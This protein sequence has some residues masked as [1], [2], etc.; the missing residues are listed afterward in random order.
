MKNK[1]F[2][3]SLLAF[4][5]LLGGLVL[6]PVSAQALSMGPNN[7]GTG[8]SV[9]GIGTI[10]WSNTG[11][12]T[13]A[14]SPYSVSG[15]VPANGGSTNYLRGTNYSLGLP[16]GSTIDGIVVKINRESTG[17]TAHSLETT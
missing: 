3:L 6:G 4:V 1:L 11:N 17:T 2:G 5:I 13:S 9:T 12:I 15:S 10:A 14:G 8:A 7:A 16:A